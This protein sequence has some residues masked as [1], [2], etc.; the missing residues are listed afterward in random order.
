MKPLCTLLAALALSC[1]LFQPALAAPDFDAAAVQALAAQRFGNPIQAA[2]PGPHPGLIELESDGQLFYTDPEVRFFFVGHIIDSLSQTDL[3]A[4]RIAQL[5][6]SSL[7]TQAATLAIRQVRGKGERTLYVF[8]DP[9]CPYCRTLHKSLEQVD[10]VTVYT[11]VSAQLSPDSAAKARAVWCAPDR[12]QAWRAWMD[13]RSA[14]PRPAQGC[15]APTEA[16]HA[17]GQ[18]LNIS[19][20]PTLLFADGSRLTGVPSATQLEQRLQAAATAPAP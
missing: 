20:T 18:R 17:L 5:A 3:T 13:Q 15:S 9:Y 19:A 1:L 14:P 2:R 4:A 16:V 10:N 11:L 7:R 8:E 6:Y 12:A